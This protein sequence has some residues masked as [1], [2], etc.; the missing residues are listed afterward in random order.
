MKFKSLIVRS[1]EEKKE[2][3]DPPS[4]SV[5]FLL[6]FVFFPRS[7]SSTFASPLFPLSILGLSSPLL[8]FTFLFLLLPPSP[9][10]FF[11]E[12]SLESLF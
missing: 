2:E 10:F 3:E 12:S 6:L 1:Q 7:L 5:C 8:P 9:D 4:L 11:L